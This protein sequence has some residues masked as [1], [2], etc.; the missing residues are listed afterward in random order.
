MASLTDQTIGS[1]YP[2]LLKIEDTGIQA[3]ASGLKYVQDGDAT[4]STLKIATDAIS[5]NASHKFFLDGGSNTYI[6]E[7]ADDVMQFFAGNENLLTLAQGTQSYV[8]FN[9][10]SL[11]V[12]FRVETNDKTH[13]LYIQGSSNKIGIN[14]I[15]SP[16]AVLH[17]QGETAAESVLKIDGSQ[18]NGFIMMADHYL[19]GE[20]QYTTG[21]TY[22]GAATYLASRCYAAT[23]A[24]Y[25]DAAGWKSSTDASSYRGAAVV[26]D[27]GAGSIS[28]YYGA[29]DSSIAPGSTRTLTR[30]LYLGEDGDVGIGTHIPGQRLHVYDD[31]SGGYVARFQNDGNNVDRHGIIIMCGDDDAGTP[32][33]TVYINCYDGNGNN[34]GSITHAASDGNLTLNATS[35]SRLK[36]NIADTKL[37]GL[38]LCNQ[39]KVR[40]FNWK[41]R[42]QFKNKAGF[43]A[44]EV[45]SVFPEAVTGT[46]NAMKTEVVSKAI[47]ELKDDQ[48]NII[49]EK[50]DEV[51]RTVID[52]MSVS[53]SSFIP[54][55]MKAVQQLSA[56]V[57]ALENA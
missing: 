45:Q 1:T 15:S 57:T 30:G 14:N 49:Q 26:V 24:V 34:V 54:I 50:V 5:I 52:P 47:N 51:T 39:I 25:T 23:D 41:K 55:L 40:E 9:E 37:D 3:F 7:S 12:D 53:Y 18:T 27:G 43:I 4:N 32:G 46:D 19:T 16:D 31:V 42:G 33:D 56:K 6:W 11:D 48:G 8:V 35:D 38:S 21:L 22:S 13:M 29:T 2:L 44:Q 20:A 10:G 17:V 36:E 28:L